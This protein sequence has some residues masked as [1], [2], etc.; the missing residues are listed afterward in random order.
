MPDFFVCFAF[1]IS[2]PYFKGY[3]SVG[4]TTHSLS[5]LPIVKVPKRA[6]NADVIDVAQVHKLIV[7]LV[8]P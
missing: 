7:W 8:C 5:L 4:L 3:L 1:V 6:R 2:E